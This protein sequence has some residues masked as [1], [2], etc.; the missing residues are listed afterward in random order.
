MHLTVVIAIVWKGYVY[1]LLVVYR[2]PSGKKV[3]LQY[4]IEILDIFIL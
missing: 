2:I 1:I 4:A 3:L